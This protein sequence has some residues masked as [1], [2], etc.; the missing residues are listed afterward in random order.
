MGEA[1]LRLLVL[2][3]F[4][5]GLAWGSLWLWR[6]TQLGLPGAAGKGRRAHLAE[7]L[8]LG[9]QGKLAVIEFGGR[10]LL[11]AVSRNQVSLIAE[12]DHD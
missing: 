7:V 6:R 11:I 5:G 12:H 3:P 8:S 4:V 10:D 1:L 2:V 9:N